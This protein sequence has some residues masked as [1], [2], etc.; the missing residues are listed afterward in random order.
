MKLIIAGATG[1]VGSELLH[2]ALRHP[3]ITSIVALARRT[4]TST[5]PYASKLTSVVVH[6]YAEY[7][8]AVKAAFAGADACIWFVENTIKATPLSPSKLIH[9]SRTVAITPFLA[10]NFDAAEVKRVCQDCMLAGFRAIH[11]SAARPFRFLY[12][13]AE[14]T[15]RELSKKPLMWGDYQIMRVSLIPRAL[16]AYCVSLTRMYTGR[17]R[18]DCA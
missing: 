16:V 6:D 18:E 3:S 17:M 7:P 8:D 12:F 4:V 5:S 13:S 15:P 14:G 2:Q 11:L 1:L 9:S 10:G